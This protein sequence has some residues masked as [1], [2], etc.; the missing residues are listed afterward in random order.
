MKLLSQHIESLIFTSEKPLKLKEIKSILEETFETKFKIADLENALEEIE[1]R[2]EGDDF[3]FEMVGIAEGYQFLTKGSYFNTVATF[4]KQTTRKRLSRAALETLSIIAYKQPVSRPEMERIR[5]VSCDYAIHK[6]LEKEMVT[7]LGRSE[8]VG[9][10]LLYGTSEKFMDYFGLKTLNDMPKPRDFNTP[11][12]SIGE[13]A[14]IEEDTPNQ[15]AKPRLELPI[16]D[17][18]EVVDMLAAILPPGPKLVIEEEVLED[19]ISTSAPTANLS[20][21]LPVTDLEEV[22]D[23]IAAVLPAESKLEVAETEIEEVQPVATTTDSKPL[24][25]IEKVID[26][27]ASILP[28]V[29]EVEEDKPVANSV[30]E[31]VGEVAPILPQASSAEAQGN[32]NPKPLEKKIPTIAELFAEATKSKL[33]I[34]ISSNVPQEANPSSVVEVEGNKVSEPSSIPEEAKTTTIAELFAEA[35]KSKSTI[36]LPSDVPQEAKSSDSSREANNNISTSSSIERPVVSAGVKEVATKQEDKAPTIAELF[37]EATKSKSTIETSSTVQEETK[38]VDKLEATTKP[39]APSIETIETS[40]LDEVVD[41]IT[42]SIPIKNI[43]TESI[44]LDELIKK[45][46]DSSEEE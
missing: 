32:V 41:V 16:T 8:A 23:M 31:T 6:L 43:S 46:E 14:P 9:K 36:E 3:A 26:D 29:S 45:N 20:L 11:E 39:P 30:T 17:L 24:T 12:N 13:A 42:A 18:E 28:Q 25:E 34:E 7:I 10:P 22:V 37:A 15:N 27:L 4:L 40:E 38:E 2:Y 44:V 35:T 33:A 21:E 19:E 1:K 5:G